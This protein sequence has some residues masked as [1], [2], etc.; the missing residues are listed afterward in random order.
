MR[1]FVV[2]LL[3]AAVSVALHSSEGS[4]ARENPATV[5]VV[6]PAA[7]GVEVVTASAGRTRNVVGKAATAVLRHGVTDMTEETARQLAELEPVIRRSPPYRA[8]RARQI[9]RQ[10][11]DMNETALA[12]LDNGRP[13]DAVRFAMRSRNLVDAVRH[14]VLEELIR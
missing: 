2:L 6:A 5:L 12:S 9:S 14:Q 13:V 8:A 10:I 1:L 11:R 7:A 3:I 4:A